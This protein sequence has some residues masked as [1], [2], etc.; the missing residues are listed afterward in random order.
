[1]GQSHAFDAPL[2]SRVVRVNARL[3]G[4]F[5]AL[6]AIVLL[7]GGTMI[8]LRSSRQTERGLARD[9]RAVVSTI[10]GGGVHGLAAYN[11]FSITLT[12]PFGVAA[13]ADGTIYIADG[14]GAHRIY[15]LS[16]DSRIQLFAGSERGF[17]DGPAVSARFDTPSGLALDATGN[18]YIA[19]T[20]N[21]AIRRV[22]PEGLVSTI[23][24][25]DAGLNGPI[26]VAVDS[27]GR[28]IVA[29]T[30]NDRV[31]A[32]DT[33][34]AVT[35]LAGSG[36]PGFEDGGAAKFHTPCGVAVDASGNIYVADAGNHAVR[37][38][39]PDGSVSTI[40]PRYG[41]DTFLP[42]AVAVS[43]GS[44]FVAD[45]RARILEITSDG[46][47]TVAGSHRGFADGSGDAALFRAP[48]AI[49]VLAQGRLIV[50][51]RR[52]GLVRLVEAQSRRELRPPAPPLDPHFD[53]EAFGRTPLLWPFTPIE[54]PFEVTGTLGEP[55]G[56]AGSERFHAGLDVH[57]PEGTPVHV[58]RDASVDDPLAANDFDSLVESVRLGPVAYIHMR[59]GR[60]ARDKPLVDDRFV[61]SRDDDGKVTGIRVKRGARFTTGETIGTVNRF[62][63]AHLNVGWP[64][65]ELNPLLFELP[66]FED[67]V[68]PVVVRGGI[69]IV[70]EDGVPFPF[71]RKR[72]VVHGRVRVFVD[73]WDQV[74]GNL[75]RRRL[76]LFRLGYQILDA[77]GA[78]I[79]GFEAPLE[80]IRFDRRPLDEGAATII[81]GSGSGI[82]VYGNRRTRFLYAVTSTLRDGVAA[83]GWFDTSVLAPGAYTLRILAADAAGNEAH[84]NRDLPIVVAER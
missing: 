3:R 74:N 38:V 75:P 47:R 82:P 43:D 5:A 57:A 20:G 24:G 39:S 45:A 64:G 60:D 46:N 2:D 55:R 26:G 62:Y 41:E 51:D 42:L 36:S 77:A 9:W 1:L 29:D 80:T 81:Y 71:L 4:V 65:E 35:T 68:P 58:V 54:G 52:N 59:V 66:G 13:A 79:E 25:A 34:G 6:I 48:S 76:G 15:Q 8:W 18:L 84:R 23:A 44:V 27:H 19:D 7:A 10:A 70:G 17:K 33:D 50:A 56:A 78:P 69:R 31:V 40:A 22:S 28:V 21:D 14:A 11:P 37:L 73:A 67:T 72:T 63:H 16:P 49:G 53:D 32:I 30:Y 83:D 12:D 61:V